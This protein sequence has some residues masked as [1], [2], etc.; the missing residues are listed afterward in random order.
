MERKNEDLK[1]MAVEDENGA[2]VEGNKKKLKNRAVED[3]TGAGVEGN[4]KSTEEQDCGRLNWGWC[5]GE[6]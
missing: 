1:N 4:K 6:K 2:G 3:E 5:G